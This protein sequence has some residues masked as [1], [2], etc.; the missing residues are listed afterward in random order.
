[1]RRLST[2]PCAESRLDEIDDRR[3]SSS[4]GLGDAVS[5]VGVDGSPGLWNPG[6]GAP[7]ESLLF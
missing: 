2:S 6:G 1:M 4:Y 7:I 3:E 5:I